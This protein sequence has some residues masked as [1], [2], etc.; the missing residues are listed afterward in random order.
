MAI[1]FSSAAHKLCAFVLIIKEKEQNINNERFA[2]RFEA[3][4]GIGVQI[5]MV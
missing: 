2:M 5:G 4:K 1:E 3:L